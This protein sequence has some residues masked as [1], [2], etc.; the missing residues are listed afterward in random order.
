MVPQFI[1]VRLST[2]VAH[3]RFLNSND[4]RASC[5]NAEGVDFEACIFLA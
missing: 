4:E 5:L 1:E 3:F 2:R